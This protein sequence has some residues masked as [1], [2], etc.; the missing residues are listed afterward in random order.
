MNETREKRKGLFYKFIHGIEIVGNKLPHPFYLFCILIVISIVLS[1]IFAGQSVTFEQAS[2]D[3]GL[4]QMVTI[5]IKN[6]I[7]RDTMVYL[8][9][10]LHKIYYSFSPMM[11]MG[12]L[13]LS[14][15]LAENV[16]FFNALIRK[17]VGNAKPAVVFA[18]VSF[19]AINANIAANGGYLALAAISASVFAAMGYNPWLGILLSYAAGNAGYSACVAIGDLDIILAGVNKSV[20]ETVG[21]DTSTVHVLSNYYFL[22]A[23]VFVLTAAFTFATVKFV[24]PYLG[25]PKD[26]SLVGVDEVNSKVSDR[27]CRALK[28]SGIAALIFVLVLIGLCIP[29][30]S[31]FRAEDGTFLPK[32]P[33]LNGVV[34]ILFLFFLV[35]GIVYGRSSGAIKSWKD[36]PGM[37]VKS[38]DLLVNFMLIALPASVFLYLFKS[39]NI[40]T[41]LGAVGGEWLESTGM[42]GFG[43]FVMIVLISTFLNL[44]VTSG[45][46]KWIMLAPILIPML[47]RIGFSPSWVTLAYRIGD[48]ATNA[49]APISSD[50]ALIVAFLMKYNT[51]KDKTPGMGTVF[52]GCMPYAITAIIAEIALAGVWWIFKLPLGPGVPIL[53]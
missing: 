47:Y 10:N 19:I 50:V 6:L 48:S 12:T 5:T 11:L 33:L 34:T 20:C 53:A 45:S 51:D 24:R 41:Y 49:V 23:S 37:L 31:F 28:K 7:E 13:V 14:L 46:T 17:C 15:G 39:S 8:L 43:L 1:V 9:E 40:P 29:K 3:G 38:L 26:L 52:A 21:I 32:S 42:N 25:E 4:P 35:I 44:F 16:G 36:L 27:E 2:R 30:N 22:L 18:V